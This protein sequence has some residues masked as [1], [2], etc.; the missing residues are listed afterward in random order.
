[1]YTFVTIDNHGMKYFIIFSS[2][3][4]GG[5]IDITFHKVGASGRLQELDTPNGGSW[6]SDNINK[7]VQDFIISLV[8]AT[9]YEDFRQKCREDFIEWLNDVE[10][11]KCSWDGKS[12][13]NLT[14]PGGLLEMH[15]KEHGEDLSQS[16]KQSPH[17]SGI[18]L[19]Y[20]KLKMHKDVFEKLF[21]DTI[22]STV[23]HIK[24][25]ISK[26]STR[27]L[28]MILLV[29]GFS[30]CELMRK[31][32]DEAF[33][34]KVDS[35]IYP[36]AEAVLAVLKGSVLYGRDPS[37]IDTRICRY[38]YGLDW[39]EEF[40]HRK[41]PRA[42][43]EYTDDGAY[44]KDIF[45]KLIQKGDTLTSASSKTIDAFP[46][47]K[48]QERIE[49]PFYRS[50]SSSVPKFVDEEGCFHLGT[51]SVELPPED[52]TL[53]SCIKLKVMFGLTELTAEATNSTGRKCSSRFN[54]LQTQI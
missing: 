18:T 50:E 11:K 1:M 37:I 43:R 46:R 16:I 45:Y 34:E 12:S 5:T 47:Y 27:K 24:S 31:R 33:A 15:K 2:N 21:K 3:V 35:I 53:D 44:C 32:I 28:D 40:D 6:G 22:E 7:K 42:K 23:E 30:D 4:V 39:N 26:L 17:R 41:H 54:L 49:F 9:V 38:T 8:G 52:R 25:V 20:N 19:Q 29:G 36:A 13:V 14:L 51:L 10:G 48:S